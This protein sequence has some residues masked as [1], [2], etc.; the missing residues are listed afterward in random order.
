MGRAL[1]LLLAL[2]LQAGCGSSSGASWSCQWSCSSNGASGSHTYPAGDD[3]TNQC[4]LDYGSGCNS[5]T[6]NCHQN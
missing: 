2:V 4:A 6:R 5:F 1:L 3:P